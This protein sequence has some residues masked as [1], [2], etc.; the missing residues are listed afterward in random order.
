MKRLLVFGAILGLALAA[1]ACTAHPT[2]D[3]PIAFAEQPQAPDHGQA[4][5]RDCL[6][7][8][9]AA[10]GQTIRAGQPDPGRGMAASLAAVST[11]QACLARH[12]LP[13]ADQPPIRPKPG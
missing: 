4:A 5:I 10:H 3:G 12:G 2:R 9:V 6:A 11:A 7:R 1:G 8:A 13:V